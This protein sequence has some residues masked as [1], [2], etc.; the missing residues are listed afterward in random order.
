[1]KYENVDIF[2]FNSYKPKKESTPVNSGT[3]E[4]AG[5]RESPAELRNESLAESRN[6]NLA[7]SRNENL[8]ELR[9][10]I[11]AEPRNENLDEINPENRNISKTANS[12]EDAPDLV[13]SNQVTSILTPDTEEI[14]QIP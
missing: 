12:V 11:P 13:T 14:L 8:D 2:T 10:E 4:N 5:S 1:M 3:E 9:N 6:E 7:E